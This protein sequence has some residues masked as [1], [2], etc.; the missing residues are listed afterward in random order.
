LLMVAT[1]RDTLAR[2]KYQVRGT[3]TGQTV[4]PTLGCGLK[5]KWTAREHFRGETEKFTRVVL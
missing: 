2:M 5:T 4:N 3:T 1:T